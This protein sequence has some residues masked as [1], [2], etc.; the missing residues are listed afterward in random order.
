MTA[1]THDPGPVP[2]SPAVIDAARAAFKT[3][4]LFD[5][6]TLGLVAMPLE[7]DAA[8]LL[9]VDAALQAATAED[10]AVLVDQAVST[11]TRQ[12][13][14]RLA[15]VTATAR[16]WATTGTRAE[17]AMGRVLMADLG[18]PA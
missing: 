5:D 11:R 14:E 7:V 18:L 6:S 4:S 12:A 16:S 2:L 1:Q 13:E 9:A 3:R 15:A 8:L 17:R 10:Y